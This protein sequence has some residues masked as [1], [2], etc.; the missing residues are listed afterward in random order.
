MTPNIEPG[1]MFHKRKL[2]FTVIRENKV[3]KISSFTIFFVLWYCFYLFFSSITK[4][5]ET[6]LRDIID[7][8]LWKFSTQT[9]FKANGTM[10]K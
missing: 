10:N 6:C 8:Y 9:E 3:E 1:E 2:I 4:Q 7:P 5:M